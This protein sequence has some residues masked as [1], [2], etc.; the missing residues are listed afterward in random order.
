MK[1]SSDIELPVLRKNTSKVKYSSKLLNNLN[2]KGRKVINFQLSLRNS[3]NN[4][5]VNLPTPLNPISNSNSNLKLHTP[6]DRTNIINLIR[7]GESVKSSRMSYP[8]RYSCKSSI[9]SLNKGEYNNK[10]KNK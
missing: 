4:S 5:S 1:K 8:I 10:S 2:N 6:Q 9:L 3:S 7:K